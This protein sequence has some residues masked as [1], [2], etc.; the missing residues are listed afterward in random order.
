MCIWTQ[1]IFNPLTTVTSEI[2]LDVP[3]DK[4]YFRIFERIFYEGDYYFTV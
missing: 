1:N 3:L 4:H 2:L